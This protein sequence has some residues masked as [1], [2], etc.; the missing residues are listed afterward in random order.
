MAAGLDT[1]AFRLKWPAG[2]SFYELDQP[3]VLQEKQQI[4]RSAGDK[5]I[6]LTIEMIKQPWE[7]ALVKADS[8]DQ[9]SVWLLEGFLFY[10]PCERVSHLL[11]AVNRLSS[12]GS[13]L[14]FDIINSITLTSP[15]TRPWIEM[16]ALSGA[17]ESLLFRSRICPP[18]QWFYLARPPG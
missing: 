18:G 14:G 5:P 6:V 10:M 9:P 8:A 16:Q 2:T 13:W 3:A 15:Y 4:L 1:R 12:P 17:R 11:D 7:N